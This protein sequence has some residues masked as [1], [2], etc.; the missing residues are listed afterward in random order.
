V[1]AFLADGES[2]STSALAQA[3]QMSQRTIQRT[4]DEL[5][6]KGKVQA[7]GRG[8]ARRWMTPAVP[9]FTTLLLLPAA[10]PAE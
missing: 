1:L 2:W 8:R 6:L 10:L 4:L 5:T 3:M 7:V 9:G